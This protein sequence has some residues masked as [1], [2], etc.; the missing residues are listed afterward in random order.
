MGRNKVPPDQKKV[1]LDVWIETQEH[2]IIIK[3]KLLPEIIKLIKEIA[4]R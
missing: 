1:R 3:N 4:K 2:E